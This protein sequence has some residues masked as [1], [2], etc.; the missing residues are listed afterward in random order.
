MINP[1][2]LPGRTARRA[3]LAVLLAAA[4]L[5]ASLAI[6]TDAGA[7]AQSA[8]GGGGRGGGGGGGG[9]NGKGGGGGP[10]EALIFIREQNARCTP[11]ANCEPYYTL[12]RKQRNEACSSDRIFLDPATWSCRRDD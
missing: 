11:G 10:N 2:S 9:G 12:R 5:P 8:G 4:A 3:L 1:V 7:L 6:G